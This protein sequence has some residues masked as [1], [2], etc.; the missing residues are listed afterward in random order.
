M[1][2]SFFNEDF[3]FEQLIKQKS[4]QYKMYPSDKVWK[5]I[6]SSLH[7][8]RKWY[9][10]GMV[11]FLAGISYY[12][13]EQ[14]ANVSRKNIASTKN[15][16]QKATEPSVKVAPNAP[17]AVILPFTPIAVKSNRTA[18]KENNESGLLI[19]LEQ[20][21]NVV[22]KV[23]T[24]STDIT[25]QNNSA[26]KAPVIS[27]SNNS[28]IQKAT[29]PSDKVLIAS[30]IIPASTLSIE[31][32]AG[33]ELSTVATDLKDVME[34]TTNNNP[35]AVIPDVEVNDK[36]SDEKRINWLQE[37]A[38]Y[39]LTQPKLKRISWQIG[40]TP[41]TNYR[42][43]VGNRNANI[44]SEAKNIP[45]ALNIQGDIDN[46]VKHTPAMG[47]EVSSVFLY[48]V[49]KNLTF[50]TGVQFNYARYEIKAYSSNATDRATIALSNF[51]GTNTD[52]ITNFTRLRNFGGTSAKNLQNQYF[53]LAVPVGLEL[54]VLGKR[55]LQLAVAGTVQPTYILNRDNYLIS[56][57]YKNYT[58][59]P[60]LVRRWNMNSSFEAFVS[61][62]VGSY[63]F[64]VGPQFRYQL[65][66]TYDDKYPVKEFLK[67]YGIKLAV[68]KSIR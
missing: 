47:F 31:N 28:A 21:D 7:S 33:K 62:K 15:N 13:I 4:D 30:T 24:V 66:S 68:S 49:N 48:Q 9:W 50:K 8:S 25:T 19:A 65:L 23:A 36:T 58:R 12:A 1:E 2:R 32:E 37:N 40:L 60:S 43:L 53:Q 55:R 6:H 52:S 38:V 39:E 63:K 14:L 54:V 42:N 45:I 3:D 10:L 29:N 34:A 17:E 26:E 16:N 27:I 5:G 11:V 57:D 46:L 18:T 67:E 22:I 56:T 64:Q 61:Y 44:A 51:Y 20:Q 59:E 35:V 41:T